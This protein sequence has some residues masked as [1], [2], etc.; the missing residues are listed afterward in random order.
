MVKLYL[1]Y[2][3]TNCLACTRRRSLG[4]L[5]QKRG[6]SIAFARNRRT[7]SMIRKLTIQT[8]SVGVFKYLPAM[9]LNHFHVLLQGVSRFLR[10]VFSQPSFLQIRLKNSCQF[11]F[12]F[13][14]SNN[15]PCLLSSVSSLLLTAGPHTLFLLHQIRPR[16]LC[17]NHAQQAASFALV[18]IILPSR[19][20]SELSFKCRALY[21][22]VYHF[23]KNRSSKLVTSQIA[24]LIP[25]AETLEMREAFGCPWFPSLIPFVLPNARAVNAVLLP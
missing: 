13:R 21:Y 23:S 6:Q 24:R 4:N 19:C 14:I 7:R 9:L 10:S 2:R 5:I 18:R 25:D 8:P 11:E 16:K 1:E 20:S 17:R 3:I 12:L 22:S 15:H